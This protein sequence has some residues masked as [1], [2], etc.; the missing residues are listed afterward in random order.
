[1][2]EIFA[3]LSQIINDLAPS[4]Q[5]VGKYLLE[6]SDEAMGLSIEQLADK[7]TASQA[8]VTRFCKKMGYKGYRDLSIQLAAQL[9]A[10]QKTSAPGEYKDIS[11]G[12]DVNTIIRNVSYHNAKAIEDSLALTDIS[13]V[14]EA[15]DLLYRAQH[16]DFYGMGASGIIAQDSM[17]KFIRINKYCTAYADPHLQ[18]TSAANLGKE[19]VAVAIS[20]SGETKDIL[21]AARQ[22]KE[23][24]A[25][26]ISITRYGETSLEAYSDVHFGLSAPETSIRC[27]ATS[28]R[29]AQLNMIDMLFY[30]IVSQHYAELYKYLERSRKVVSTKR[31]QK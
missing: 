30:C 20:W 25:S 17:Y 3:K 11:V 5:K 12:D 29:I 26:V 27:G 15:A 31:E 7:S 19:G 9:A 22:A 6:H 4:E 24:G 18:I 23:S 14:Q 1:M 28:S 2:A 21:E 10:E 8:A 16:I 13:L